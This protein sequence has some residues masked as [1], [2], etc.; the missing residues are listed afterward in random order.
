MAAVLIA[1]AVPVILPVVELNISPAGRLGAIENVYGV[2]P[3][4]A[5]TGITAD[6]TTSMVAVTVAALRVVNRAGGA[7]TVRLNV[8]VLVCP[9]LSVTVTVNTVC[10]SVAVA[11]PDIN[12]EPVFSV[13]PVGRLGL[14]EKVRVP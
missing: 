4:V 9:M 7:D 14:I 13:N 2:S 3:P 5:V 11:V 8:L 1:V 10:A 6:N 12:P